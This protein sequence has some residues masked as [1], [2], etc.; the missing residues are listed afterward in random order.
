MPDQHEVNKF[1]IFAVVVVVV[2]VLFWM[3]K[4]SKRAEKYNAGNNIN[5]RKT[6]TDRNLPASVMP[7]SDVQNIGS[8]FIIIDNP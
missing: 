6:K 7:H 5:F 3:L 2:I 4:P 1:P 8:P